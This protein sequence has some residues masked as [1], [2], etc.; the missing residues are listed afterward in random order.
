MNYFLILSLVVLIYMS[1]WFL[2]SLLLKRNDIADVAWGIG[3]VVLAWASFLLSGNLHWLVIIV[4]LLVTVW[5]LR[6]ALHIFQRNRKKSE[7]YRYAEWRNA[8][9][10]FFYVRSYLQVFLLQGLFLYIISIPVIILNKF[11]IQTTSPLVF[12]G[13]IVWITGF[14]FETVGDA[15]LS[16]FMS[17]ATNKGKVLN[18][19]LWKYTRHPN[20]FGEVTQWWGIWLIVIIAT[21]NW[22]SILGPLL[23]T[24][25]ILKVSGIPLLEK[26]MATQPAFKE[27]MEKT[28][29]FIPWFSRK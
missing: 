28:S 2:F 23:I 21:G 1:A 8:W 17:D 25:L 11:N 26:K 16:K 15:Q 24:F 19:G 13:I 6:L 10:K 9:G 18:T 14:I 27:Y 7:D 29:V 12:L 3:F 4:N 5:G 20:Y 22:V